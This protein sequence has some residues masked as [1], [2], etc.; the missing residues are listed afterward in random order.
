VLGGKLVPVSLCLPQIP[1][2]LSWDPGAHPE[3]FLLDFKNCVIE[4]L[5]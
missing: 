5:S 3:L 2:G 1:H 4:I